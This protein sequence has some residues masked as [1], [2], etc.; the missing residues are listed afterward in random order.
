LGRFYK[1]TGET[2]KAIEYFSKAKELGEKN[3]IL[4]IVQETAKDLDTLYEKKGDLSRLI[5]IMRCIINIRTAV[6]N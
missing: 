1:K 4:E 6:K 5:F 3:G 2:A